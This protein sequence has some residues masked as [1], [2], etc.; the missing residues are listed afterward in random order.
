MEIYNV[1]VLWLLYERFKIENVVFY[2]FVFINLLFICEFRIVIQRYVQGD[3]WFIYIVMQYVVIF[4]LNKY[5][6]IINYIIFIIEYLKN[7]QN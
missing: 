6:Q 1:E 5:I 4:Y 3:K 7:V 2:F